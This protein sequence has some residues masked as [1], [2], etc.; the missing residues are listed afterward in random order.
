M[1]QVLG[2]TAIFLFAC[3]D[4]GGPTRP[5]NDAAPPLDRGMDAAPSSDAAMVDAAPVDLGADAH[6][7]LVADEPITEGPATR[8]GADDLTAAVPMGVARA[9]Q[10]NAPSEALTG[11]DARCRPGCYRLDNALIKVCIQG[12]STFS[13]ITFQGGNLIDACPAAGPCSDRLREINVTPGLGEVSVESIGIVRDGTEGGAAI[14]RTVGRAGGGRTIQAYVPNGAL[15][16]PVKV[17]TEYRLY[18]DQPYV[19]MLTWMAADQGGAGFLLTDMVL[20]GDRTLP[21]FPEGPLGAAP[22]GRV[23]YL[24]ATGEEVA[25]RFD[26]P[27]GPISV[28]NIPVDSFP[29][30]PVTYGQLAIQQGDEILL[31]RRFWVGADIEAVREAPEGALATELIGTPGAWVDVD[32]GEHQVT[33]AHLGA[34]GHRKIQLAPGSYRALATDWPGGEPAPTAFAAG[35][36]VQL[37]WPAPARLRVQVR[38]DQGRSIGAKV[39]LSSGGEE[40]PEFVLGEAELLLPPGEWRVVTTRGWHYTVDDQVLNLV[41]GAESALDVRLTEVIPFDG[42]SAGEFHQHSTSSLDSE[43]PNRTRILSNIAEGVGFMVPSDHDIIF[44]FQGLARQMGVLDRIGLPLV[45]AEVSPLFGHLGAYG[46]R[47]DPEAGAGGAPPLPVRE[48]ERWRVSTT[49]ELVAASRER[50]A[51]IIQMNHPRDGSAWLDAVDFNV[52]VPVEA[53]DSPNWTPDFESMEVYNRENDFCRVLTDWFGLLNQG[54]HIT[55]VGN[56]DTHGEGR[57]PG[58]PRNYVRTAAATAAEVSSAEIITAMREG[59]SIMGAGAVMDF[60]FGPLPGDTVAAPDGMLRL[61][62]RLRTPP[63][64]S[65]NRLLAFHNG[66]AVYDQP[67]DSPDAQIVDHDA[68]IAIPVD[69]DGPVVVLALGNPRLPYVAS[70]PVFALAN[71]VWVD[72]DGDGQI[73]P[74]GPG[75]IT[76]PDMEICP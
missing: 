24:A 65:I 23:P 49:P 56:S 30:R 61:H 11:V 74:A 52:E 16:Q 41:E 29:L 1:R 59:R 69:T 5:V 31:R 37:T 15:P 57:A 40:R 10:V 20:Y 39:L 68:E 6:I 2:W 64:T 22:N 36:A 35:D 26:Q 66:R 55:A 12:A 32:D 18:P 54:L 3:D 60:P 76:L 4:G 70:G 51:Q 25:Y 14:V 34:D 45:G 75:P 8:V 72:R 27:T 9:G 38:D 33:R 28:I 46:L 71:P 17:T 62:V 21:F 50:G 19:E 43:V 63:Y 44:D 13:Q 47:Y 67:V 73:T 53:L 7:P 42:W 58:Y 48:G